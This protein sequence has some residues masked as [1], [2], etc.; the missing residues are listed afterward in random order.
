[1]KIQLFMENGAFFSSIWWKSFCKKATSKKVEMVFGYFCFGI[2]LQSPN[3]T[4]FQIPR[5]FCEWIWFLE[6]CWEKC[7]EK[8]DVFSSFVYCHFSAHCGLIHSWVLTGGTY[9][10]YNC[11]PTPL[12]PFYHI[13]PSIASTFS[14][15]PIQRQKQPPEKYPPQMPSCLRLKL[16]EVL[17]SLD[18][19]A[20]WCTH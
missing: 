13:C 3:L 6:K 2:S 15:F 7:W 8:L 4:T 14:N 10:F 11:T 12:C 16:Q 17:N 18:C 1:M 5:L 19:R 9:Y 20:K